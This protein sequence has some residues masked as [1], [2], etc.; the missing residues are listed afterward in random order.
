MMSG[1]A[2]TQIAN[3]DSQGQPAKFLPG[4]RVFVLVNGMM[5]TV[6]RQYLHYDGP[7]NF[8]GNVLLRYDDG[9][10]GISNSWQLKHLDD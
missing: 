8:W 4:A 5:A 2:M 3:V 1:E 10:T 6:V 9:I 7:E